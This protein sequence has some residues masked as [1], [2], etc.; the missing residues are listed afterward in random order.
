MNRDLEQILDTA[1]AGAVEQMLEKFKEDIYEDLIELELEDDVDV[2]EVA[3]TLVRLFCLNIRDEESR[4]QGG[5]QMMLD[6]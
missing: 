6:Q 2:A 3:E 4:L 1:V 5:L